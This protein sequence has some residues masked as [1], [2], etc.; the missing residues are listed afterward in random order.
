MHRKTRRFQ[1]PLRYTGWH[2]ESAKDIKM[3]VETLEQCGCHSAQDCYREESYV[4]LGLPQA[5]SKFCLTQLPCESVTVPSSASQDTVTPL[6]ILPKT[7]NSPGTVPLK[8]RREERERWRRENSP[9]LTYCFLVTLLKK[10]SFHCSWN[11]L[12]VVDCI[13]KISPC[14]NP[15]DL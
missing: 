13:E 1:A 10:C 6:D 15:W 5:T 2:L 4:R 14:P 8:G 3:D 9:L 12:P 11:M 7:A